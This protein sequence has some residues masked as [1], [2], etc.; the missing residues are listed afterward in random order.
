MLI[1]NSVNLTNLS[2]VAKSNSVC[3]FILQG[4][5]RNTNTQHNL[6]LFMTYF[7][8]MAVV[9]H[10]NLISV[11]NCAESVCY[12]NNSSTF[13]RSIKRFLYNLL[14]F[15]IQSADKSEKHPSISR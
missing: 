7:D 6:R 8:D 9:E 4:M 13:D 5:R 10:R 3:I 11:L 2:Q 15:C 12:N 1:F 14:G